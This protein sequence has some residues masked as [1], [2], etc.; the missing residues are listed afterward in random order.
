[1]KREKKLY[2]FKKKKKGGGGGG[3]DLRPPGIEPWPTDSESDVL[4]ILP[5]MHMALTRDQA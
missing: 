1:M 2:Y 5:S 4:T 3:I